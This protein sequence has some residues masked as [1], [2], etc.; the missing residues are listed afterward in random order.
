MKQKG[1]YL[2]NLL[3]EDIKEKWLINYY[4]HPGTHPHQ[5]DLDIDK[6]LDRNFSN[7]H[8]FISISFDW[9]E[10]PEGDNYWREIAKKDIN[11]LIQYRRNDKLEKLGI[12]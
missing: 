3:S 8:I 9:Y 5:L 10:T 6:F 1:T 7:F 11:E 12:E 4:N 2:F